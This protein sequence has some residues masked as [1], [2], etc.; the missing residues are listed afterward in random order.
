MNIL[1]NRYNIKLRYFLIFWICILASS[2]TV[3][4]VIKQEPQGVPFVYET[5][6]KVHSNILTKAQNLDLT[7]ILYEQIDDSSISKRLDKVI[8]SVAKNPPR[9]DSGSIVKSKEYIKYKLQ[10]FGFFRD[11]INYTTEIKPNK[12]KLKTY[13]NFNV[14]L[15][16]V[17][18]I[19]S[20]HYHAATPELQHIMDSVAYKGFINIGDP[21]AQVP[22][23]NELDKLVNVFK[24]N[25]YIKFGRDL[26]FVEWD[27]LPARLLQPSLNPLEQVLILQELKDRQTKPKATVGIEMHPIDD[28]TRIQKYYIGD[29]NIFPDTDQSNPTEHKR[30]T[31]IGVAN[32]FQHRKSFNPKMFSNLVYIQKGELYRQAKFE[33]TL[34][35]INSLSAFRLVNVDQKIKTGEDSIDFDF[36]LTPAKRYSYNANIESS[37]NQTSLAGI[38]GIA[39]NTGIQNRNFLK[40][41]NTLSLNGSV[42][43]ELGNFKDGDVFQAKQY[44][45][46]ATVNFPRFIAPGF[47]NFRQKF[48]GNYNTLLSMSQ[49]FTDRRRLYTLSSFNASWAYDFIWRGPKYIKNNRI[50]NLNIRIPNIE[51]ASL[52]KKDS[53]IQLIIQNPSIGNLFSDGLVL[54]TNSRF[55]T[56]W[57][58]KNQ[59]LAHVLRVG[60]EE[61]GLLSGFIRTKFLDEQLYRF[62]KLDLE[63]ARLL[64]IH[65]SSFVFRSYIG[66][67]HEL[68]S[69]QNPD[70]RNKLPFFKQYFSGGSNSM[71]AWGLRRLGPGSVVNSFRG[72]GSYPD[73]FGD[74]QLE[75]NFEYRAPLFKIVG[76]P[77][78]GAVFTDIGNIWYLNNKVAGDEGRFKLSK[79]GKDIA[80]GSGVGLRI[81]FDFLIIRFDYGY[82]VKDPSPDIK[83][84]HYQNKFFAYPL[85]KGSQFQLGINY[86]FIY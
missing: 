52:T 21:F 19:D 27:T 74:F 59:K 22:L 49:S 29:V 82:K 84:A 10:S 20:L 44:G 8:Y 83:D 72:A 16:P 63:Y 41:G 2:C 55:T 81:D 60:F 53:L 14:F 36:K 12:D 13:I 42:G 64:H 48:K 39:L 31:N 9:L 24:Q 65:K 69:T 71:R 45:L 23:S 32:V 35:A 25:G 78:N 46:N 38:L 86:P 54:S 37:I 68:N 17:T 61:S 47:K 51:Y 73:R 3:F 6:I 1:L 76:I 40:W 62:I 80:I 30:E 85:I 79:L 77:I 33:R 4:T 56:Q 50:N 18:K 28:S 66:V 5:N 15:G 58:T 34:N 67:G 70:K 7:S 75:S 43:V 11:S 26:L 57:N